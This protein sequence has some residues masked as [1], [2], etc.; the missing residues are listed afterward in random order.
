MKIF[1]KY[2]A[3]SILLLF[4]ILLINEWIFREELDN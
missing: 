2:F 4:I 1:V 3:L